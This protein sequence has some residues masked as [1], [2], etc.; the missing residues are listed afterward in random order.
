M[1]SYESFIESGEKFSY[2]RETR[3]PGGSNDFLWHRFEVEVDVK[4][5]LAATVD[6][7][8]AA[9]SIRNGTRQGK[10]IIMLDLRD[11][12]LTPVLLLELSRFNQDSRNRKGPL[13]RLFAFNKGA[14]FEVILK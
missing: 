2:I 6:Y 12:E 10:S 9:R 3:R 11:R 14:W 13:D 4:T 7:V 1:E 8:A 5:P